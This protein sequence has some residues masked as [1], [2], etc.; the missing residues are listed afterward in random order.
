MVMYSKILINAAIATISN[1]LLN[2]LLIV[3]ILKRTV[4]EM[5]GYSRLILLHSVIDIFYGLVQVSI[6]AASYFKP[7]L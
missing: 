7:C 2:S 1:I 5:K 6:G 3:L 4:S